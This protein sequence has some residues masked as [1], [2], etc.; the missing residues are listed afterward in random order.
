MF[1]LGGMTLGYFEP[2]VS[3]APVRNEKAASNA[4]RVDVA[5]EREREQE[6]EWARAFVTPWHLF[7]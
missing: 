1:Y 7:Y 2:P 6:Q 4:V 3:K 5:A